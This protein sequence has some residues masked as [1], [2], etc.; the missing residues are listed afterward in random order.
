MDFE[1]VELGDITED[2][3]LAPV[4]ERL[5]RVFG[6]PSMSFMTRLRDS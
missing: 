4:D 2:E 1:E 3:R 6:V 5:I